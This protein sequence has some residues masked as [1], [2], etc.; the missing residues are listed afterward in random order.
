MVNQIFKIF[1]KLTNKIFKKKKNV[2]EFS[3][4]KL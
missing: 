4:L 1:E 3:D 2:F